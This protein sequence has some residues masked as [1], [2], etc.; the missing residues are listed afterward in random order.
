[1]T[2][3]GKCT[4]LIKW[5]QSVYNEYEIAFDITL[6]NADDL[7]YILSRQSGEDKYRE[8]GDSFTLQASRCKPG[9]FGFVKLNKLEISGS[10]RTQPGVRLSQLSSIFRTQACSMQR[11]ACSLPTL[12]PHYPSQYERS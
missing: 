8:K 6:H 9:R 5:Q 12:S 3:T 2:N 10:W 11:E 4:E 1:M 7:G